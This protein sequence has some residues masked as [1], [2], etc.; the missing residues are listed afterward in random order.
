MK[1]IHTLLDEV[2]RQPNDDFPMLKVTPGVLSPTIQS[3][4]HSNFLASV[5]YLPWANTGAC[6]VQMFDL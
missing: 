4:K 2:L 3:L 1:T 5:L 6:I